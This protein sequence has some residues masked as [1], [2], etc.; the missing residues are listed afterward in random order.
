MKIKQLILPML[1]I[2]FAI[3]MVFATTGLKE[4]PN[5]QANDYILVN[6]SWQ[7]IDEQ[8]CTGL[9]F[10]CQVQFG[11]NGPRYDVYD[12]MNDDKPKTSSSTDPIIIN[13]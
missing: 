5:M 9:G 12:K 6:G 10:T 8:N 4:E 13:P 3:S 7:T 1:A 2:I 11:T